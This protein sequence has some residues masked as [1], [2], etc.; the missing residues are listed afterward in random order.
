MGEISFVDA[1]LPSASVVPLEDSHV[2]AVPKDLLLEKL[3]TDSGFSSRFY[4]ALAVFLADRLRTTT[5]HL[6]YG[7]WP[8]DAKTDEID[9]AALD[10]ISL[11]ARRFD[12]MLHRLRVAS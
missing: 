2:F 10:D 11:A 1:R 3:E 5:A 12:E 4:R 8:A 6:G 9:D 7:T